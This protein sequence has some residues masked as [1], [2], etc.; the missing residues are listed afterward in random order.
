MPAPRWAAISGIALVAG[1]AGAL[2]TWGAELSGQIQVAERDI[3]RLG[4]EPDPLAIPLLERFAE[5]VMDAPAPAS[6]TEMYALWRGS[7]LGDQGYP[8]Q[9]A[10]WTSNGSLIEELALDSLDLPLSLLSTMVRELDPDES[11]RVAAGRARAGS[12]LRPHG[13]AG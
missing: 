12:A 6:G 11:Q 9:L 2:V 7:A 1:S 3:A 10:L 5:Q 8:S 13:A 4:D